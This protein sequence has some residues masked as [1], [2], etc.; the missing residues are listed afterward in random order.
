M[1][2]EKLYLSPAI[3]TVTAK[4]TGN[5]F[6]WTGLVKWTANKYFLLDSEDDLHSVLVF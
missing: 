2:V 6:Q 5:L 1:T 4:L 3:M